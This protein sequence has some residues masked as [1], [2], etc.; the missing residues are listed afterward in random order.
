MTTE[1]SGLITHP[2]NPKVRPMTSDSLE[3]VDEPDGDVLA[4]E[5]GLPDLIAFDDIFAQDESLKQ[6]LDKIVERIQPNEN[7]KATDFTERGIVASGFRLKGMPNVL[8][9]NKFGYQL[10][11]GVLRD[12]VGIKQQ[13]AGLNY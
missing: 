1:R 11:K 2:S 13:I 12:R 6:R 7:T 3:F 9:L 10:L 5:P 8:T 4:N